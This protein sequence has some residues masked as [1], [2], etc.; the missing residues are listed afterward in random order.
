[1]PRSHDRVPTRVGNNTMILIYAKNAVLLLILYILSYDIFTQECESSATGSMKNNNIGLPVNYFRLFDN[2]LL[3]DTN[4][5][6]SGFKTFKY[7]L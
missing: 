2:D 1:M 4:L 6:L 3:A 7:L 5:D